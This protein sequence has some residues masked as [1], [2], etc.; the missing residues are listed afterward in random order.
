MTVQTT[1]TTINQGQSVTFSGSLNPDE[2]GR[3]IYLER[4]NALGNQWHIIDSAVV[5]ANSQYSL[6]ESFYVAGSETVR[7]AI[8]GSPANQGG[9]TASIPITVKMIP[10]T[11]LVPAA[12]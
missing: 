5:G 10:V 11:A 2:T 12:G 1:P 4:L 7:V 3:A 9:A 6:T 8:P